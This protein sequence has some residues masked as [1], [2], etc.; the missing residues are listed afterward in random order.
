MEKTA[1]TA[2]NFTLIRNGLVIDPANRLEKGPLDVLL[3]GNKIAAVGENLGSDLP[4][5][6]LEVFDAS[7]CIVCP[8]LIDLH[9]HGFPGGS[10]LGIDP[11]QYCLKGGVTT[12]VDAGSAGKW[13]EGHNSSLNV[14]IIE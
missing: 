5:D 11:D 6:E 7:G 1:K 10:V 2:Q 3:S 4:K 13:E 9:I 8:G 14:E 12:V